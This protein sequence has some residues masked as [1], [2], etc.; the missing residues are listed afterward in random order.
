MLR[1]KS[2]GVKSTLGSTRNWAATFGCC[3]IH[4]ICNIWLCLISWLHTTFLQN[5]LNTNRAECL[6]HSF[7]VHNSLR[8]Q[9]CS[10]PCISSWGFRWW[11]LHWS[12]RAGPCRPHRSPS[13]SG[14]ASGIAPYSPKTE[15]NWLVEITI[16]TV[17]LPHHF[18]WNVRIFVPSKKQYSMLGCF[19]HIQYCVWLKLRYFLWKKNPNH[20]EIAMYEQALLV[21]L[22]SFWVNG[23][24]IADKISAL[25]ER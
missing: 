19:H 10:R 2:R 5:Y 8:I 7:W 17:T 22:P 21:L 11:S 18:T 13:H 25:A 23:I 14:S 9:R 4:K 1:L 12:W 16:T 15:T 3:N 24:K 6:H 20:L